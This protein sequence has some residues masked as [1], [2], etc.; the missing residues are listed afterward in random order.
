M[1]AFPPALQA[2]LDAKKFE[3]T[4]QDP[5]MRAETE[6]G[7]VITRPR[8]TRRPRRSWT[9]GLTNIYD[10][11]KATLEAFWNEVRGG[12][13][14]FDLTLPITGEVV[15]VRFADGSTMKFEYTGSILQDDGVHG[16]RW[17]VSGLTVQEV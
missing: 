3:Q 1:T 2:R 17:D 8:F 16:G 15:P 9:L 6:G 14:A 12:S 5:A 4:H 7:Y 10:D 11:D 13:T